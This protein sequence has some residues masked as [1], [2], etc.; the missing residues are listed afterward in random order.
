[1][2][3][4]NGALSERQFFPL[5]LLESTLAFYHIERITL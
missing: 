4:S 3:K 5:S 2:N 1:M